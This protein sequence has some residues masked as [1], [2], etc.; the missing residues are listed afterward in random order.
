M[1]PL[2]ANHPELAACLLAC[3]LTASCTQSPRPRPVSPTIT[4]AFFALSVSNLDTVEAWYV[5]NLGF[6]RELRSSPKGGGPRG[7]ILVRE[8]ARLELLEFATSKPRAAWGL[9]PEA[10]QVQGILKIGFEVSD[11]DALFATAQK[12]HLD[13]FFPLVTPPGSSLRTFGL[14]DPDG[15]IVQFFGK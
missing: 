1:R 8:G 5:E 3:C 12:R 10:E 6:E 11:I 13:V 9:P 14:R 7:E 15:N 2:R 4:A